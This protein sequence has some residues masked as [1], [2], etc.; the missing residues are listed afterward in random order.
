MYA[1]S[2]SWDRM[3][4]D[5]MRRERGGGEG[6]GGGRM[7][8]RGWA[9]MRCDA[10]RS[11]GMGS[12]GRDS[13][14]WDGMH[15]IGLLDPRYS[16]RL[17]CLVHVFIVLDA[18]PQIGQRLVSLH[19]HKVWREPNL[20]VHVLHEDRGIVLCERRDTAL[21]SAAQIPALDPAQ[22]HC[23]RNRLRRAWASRAGV[24]VSWPLRR[25]PR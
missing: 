18:L 22:T 17:Y 6:R 19:P 3:G 1:P 14:G 11:V 7:D 25:W 2:S 21:N 23:A 15:R 8:G 9:A 13:D 5:V 20:G 4:R 12:D 24:R 10:M 16:T